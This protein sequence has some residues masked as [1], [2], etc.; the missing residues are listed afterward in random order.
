MYLRIERLVLEDIKCFEKIT[1]RFNEGVNVISG[2]NGSGKSTIITSIGF[3]LYGNSYLTGLNLTNGD[4]V[5]R[6]AEKGKI[7]LTFTTPEGTFVSRHHIRA[8]GSD[9]WK[10]YEKG[11]DK[12]LA[13]GVTPS[14]E[15]I[16][17]LI[18]E[19]IDANTFKAA[20]CA[21][22]G[23]LTDLLRDT[24]GER[25]KQVRKILGLESFAKTGN[26]MRNY[27]KFV[28][29]K[30]ESN[31]F[32]IAAIDETKTDKNEVQADITAQEKK[33]E[34][35]KQE[36]T[37]TA[38]RISSLE[39]RVQT[40]KQKKNTIEIV[41]SRI[42]TAEKETSD[43]SSDLKDNS[44]KLDNYRDSFGWDKIDT[45]GADRLLQTKSSS[46]LKLT[47]SISTNINIKENYEKRAEELEKL[48]KEHIQNKSD[49]DTKK[50]SSKEIEEEMTENVRETKIQELTEKIANYE[51]E[52]TR[53]KEKYETFVSTDLELKSKI[54]KLEGEILANETEFR[55]VF[56]QNIANV[57]ELLSS[58]MS[59]KEK[60]T[61]A[62]EQ[63][64]TTREE[65]LEKSA[66][67]KKEIDTVQQTIEL[68]TS[69]EDHDCPIC[70][71]P[72]EGMDTSELLRT[73]QDIIHRL[74][75]E[76]GR[77]NAK[78][79][80]LKENI[81]QLQI[82]LTEIED[83]LPKLH[84]FVKTL[85]YNQTKQTELEKIKVELGKLDKDKNVASK[86]YEE[87]KSKSV[88]QYKTERS[89]LET[90]K[91][92]LQKLQ[93]ETE[94]LE[95][96][97]QSMKERM[98]KL[99]DE[100]Q[101]IDI[102][103][104]NKSLEKEGDEVKKLNQE[105]QTLNDIIIPSARDMDRIS[106]RL[107]ELGKQLSK[108]KEEKAELEKEFDGKELEKLDTELADA[109]SMLGGLKERIKNIDE[110]LEEL[111]NTLQKAEEQE[112]NLLRL[113]DEVDEL[114]K[115]HHLS[116]KYESILQDA[117]ELLISKT[118][119]QISS[120]LTNMMKRMLPNQGFNKVAF[121][122][123]G[124]V[125]LYNGQYSI[126]KN[127]LSGGEKTVLALALRLALA[128]FVAPLNFL[129]LDEP[130]NHLDQKRIEEF[131]EII[132]REQLFTASK[133]QLLLVTHKVEFD[134]NAENS[135]RLQIVDG[136][137]GHYVDP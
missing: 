38:G 65:L 1:F 40:L 59:E 35:V 47:K 17:S 25:S 114:R 128:E 9:V 41:L 81:D 89:K 102:E 32:K 22:Q 107:K 100:N 58:A 24:P 10:V 113:N 78:S 44:S 31:Q 103:R 126:D 108:D 86:A 134:R 136:I 56:D 50:S 109:I 72:F 79:G 64:K 46:L 133:G 7:E 85:E 33:Q 104:L 90:D 132:D 51:S 29:S 5:K 118:A 54:E 43:L 95:A 55:K 28:A 67:T 52:L 112:I 121:Q 137:R 129:T 34:S 3:G 49:L 124:D 20:L 98:A 4:L 75:D 123:D 84:Q 15:M 73:Q 101:K 92:T 80:N 19:G 97:I 106:R 77:Q 8:S 66:S 30:I 82:R 48:E 127:T 18:G 135:I 119:S 68:L 115:L 88:D 45:D 125:H 14:K 130:T 122:N 87:L 63:L 62:L 120:Y 27:G 23:E 37:A 36:I 42:T 71:R 60:T 70:R 11:S 16:Q 111:K 21:R 2:P 117:P 26:V 99:S 61:I 6:D 131:M 13:D 94:V 96:N 91:K 105:I 110:R 76:N 53:L 116:E 39:T 12:V 69:H 83:K 74:T 57:N 93:K